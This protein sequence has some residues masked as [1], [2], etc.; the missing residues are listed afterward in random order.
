MFS[1]GLAIFVT[2]KPMHGY[3]SPGDHL[4]LATTRGDGDRSRGHRGHA[5]AVLRNR[6]FFRAPLAGIV[7][8]HQDLGQADAL[9]VGMFLHTLLL[10]LTERA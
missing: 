4:T 1:A 5:A 2:M 6:E 9:R 8:M 3:T 10:A 7:C